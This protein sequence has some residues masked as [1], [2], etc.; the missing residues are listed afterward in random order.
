M[1]VK[2]LCAPVC[3]RLRSDSTVTWTVYEDKGTVILLRWM[4]NG[5]GSEDHTIHLPMGSTSIKSLHAVDETGDTIVVHHSNTRFDC[6]QT[7]GREPLWTW[8]VPKQ[9]EYL[10]FFAASQS[11]LAEKHNGSICLTV[12]EGLVQFF[13]ILPV[14][15]PSEALRSFQLTKVSSFLKELI[16]DDWHISLC[17]PHPIWNLTSTLQETP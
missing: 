5:V 3:I 11:P 2:F 9:P 15:K 13:P 6:Y 8:H 16:S 7:M 14:T 1:D 4:Q 10:Q 17:L 12:L